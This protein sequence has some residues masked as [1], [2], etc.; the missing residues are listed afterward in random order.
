MG[1]CLVTRHHE[2][3]LSPGTASVSHNT[4]HNGQHLEA[5]TYAIKSE[6]NQCAHTSTTAAQG[7]QHYQ[8]AASPMLS[9]K[10]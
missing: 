1:K 10:A 5:W 3:A 7:L 2:G 6:L 8:H 9:V 4:S